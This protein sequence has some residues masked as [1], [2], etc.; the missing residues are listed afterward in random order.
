MDR[1]GYAIEGCIIHSMWGSYAGSISW[2]KNPK[3]KASAHYCI[4]SDGEITLTVKED[5]AAWHAGIVSV[6]KDQA[7]ELLRN[8][9]AVNPNFIT[10]G[11]ELE[12]LRQRNRVYPDPQYQ[13]AVELIADICKRHNILADRGHIVLHK[14]IDP[15]H[16]SDPV[17]KWNHDKFIQDVRLL[18]ESQEQG[19]FGVTIVARA[20][21]NVRETPSIKGVKRM[22]IP[23]GRTIYVK[24]FVTGDTV[25]D[26]NKWWKTRDNLFVWSG[27]TS[28]IPSDTKGSIMTIAEKETRQL[29][30]AEKAR[31]LEA[32]R[33]DLES[34]KAEVSNLDV[35]LA[36]EEV[37]YKAEYEAFL[38]EPV[39]EP[40]PE[41]NIDPVVEA[42]PEVVEALVEEKKVGFEIRDDM[43]SDIKDKIR[44]LN[45]LMESVKDF[46][47]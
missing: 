37:A 13:S 2:F 9:W 31:V 8:R 29:E 26:N 18:L 40:A 14:E 47:K 32:R 15:M 25:L 28:N 30:L 16:R 12:D 38:A 46:I 19:Y 33:A 43:P 10:I 35:E 45:S 23:Y 6:Q 24:D 39:V 21:V 4:R 34:K 22:V 3:A 36:N 7:P 44:I 1:E 27:G 11:I 42:T 20:G 41:I 17:G 5:H